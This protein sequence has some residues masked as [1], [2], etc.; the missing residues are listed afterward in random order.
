[1]PDRPL[2]LKIFTLLYILNVLLTIQPTAERLS[3]SAEIYPPPFPTWYWISV[4]AVYLAMF[5]LLAAVWVRNRMGYVLA[6]LF[7]SFEVIWDIFYITEPMFSTFLILESAQL[8][9]LLSL[10]TY[11]FGKP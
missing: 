8:A 5:I 3:R 7:V 4:L 6:L 10:L 1:V 9:L 2:R 11:F